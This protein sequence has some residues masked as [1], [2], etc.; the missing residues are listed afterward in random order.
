VQ[1]GV[2]NPLTDEKVRQTMSAATKQARA[3]PTKDKRWQL[4]DNTMRRYGYS[5]NALIET[6]HAAQESFA[7]LDPKTLR[8]VAAS[9]HLPLSKVYGVA[10]FYHHFTLRPPGKHTCVVCM[11]TA[12]YIKGA[13]QLLESL[14]KEYHVKAGQ[15]TKDGKLSVLVARCL[16]SCGLAPAAVFD[17]EVA[18]KLNSTDVMT[19]V[20]GQVADDN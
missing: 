12:C 2:P 20:A 17:G 10:T 15:T 6:L 13:A 1:A 19:R 5:G 11:G 16:G 8:S 18:G 14:E 4:V 9:L 3:T 7:Y